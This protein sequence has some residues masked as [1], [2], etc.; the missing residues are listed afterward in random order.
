MPALTNP[1]PQPAPG[2]KP[3]PEPHRPSRLRALLVLCLIAGAGVAAYSYW[4]AR[5]QAAAQQAAV[6]VV[7]TTTLH[8]G[9]IE[10]KVRL[11]GATS[12][13]NYVN[14]TAPRLRGPTATSPCC[15]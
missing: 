12:A 10:T 15:C 9:T 1:T 14:L 6:G 3:E 7:R 4:N 2:V 11:T 8:R 5:K 13:R